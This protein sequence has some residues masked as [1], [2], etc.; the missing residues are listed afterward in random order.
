MIFRELRADVS[1]GDGLR[2]RQRALFWR[3]V[4][5]ARR[6]GPERPQT[7]NIISHSAHRQGRSEGLD[8]DSLTVVLSKG[9]RW[10][11]LHSNTEQK[12]P[13]L[14]TDPQGACFPLGF[15]TTREKTPKVRPTG[16]PHAQGLP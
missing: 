4:A 15:P 14:S 2:R 1:P 16:F 8:H 6:L 10:A 11:H 12:Q 3:R 5:C 7:P 9:T 13:K